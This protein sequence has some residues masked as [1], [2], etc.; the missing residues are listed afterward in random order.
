[1]GKSEHMGPNVVVISWYQII[2]CKS[3]I[4]LIFNINRKWERRCI[5]Y[6]GSEQKLRH[7]TMNFDFDKV[8]LPLMAVEHLKKIDAI[9]IY[10]YLYVNILNL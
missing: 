9:H 10:R 1:M 6:Y 2:G 8:L 5:S 7:R 3:T 4:Y